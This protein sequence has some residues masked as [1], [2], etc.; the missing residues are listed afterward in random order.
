MKK[1]KV[2]VGKDVIEL[3]GNAMYLDPLTVY[4]EYIQNSVDSIDEAIKKGLLGG[5]NDGRIEINID[6]AN[7]RIVI[8]DN[9]IGITKE[10]FERRMTSIGG[11][12]KR[13]TSARGFRG[14]GRLAGLGFCQNLI[15]RSRAPGDAV[16]EQ[17]WDVRKIKSAL[18]EFQGEGDIGQLIA[19]V[20]ESRTIDGEDYPDHFF[21]VEMKSPL[22]LGQDL[23]MNFEK[24]RSYVGQVAPVPFSQTFSYAG[25]VRD[26]LEK[27]VDFREYP[28]FLNDDMGQIFKPYEDSFDYSEFKSGKLAKLELFQLSSL[29]GG[30]GAVGWVAH[31]DYQ[32][33]IP[34]SAGVGGLRARVGNMQIGERNVFVD[35]FPEERF[36]SWTI[37]EVHT[38][39]GRLIPNGRR[40]GFEH[41]NHLT[42]L[43]S[44]LLPV[45]HAIAQH[46]RRESSIRNQSKRV[47]LALMHAEAI[48]EMLDQNAITKSAAK[49]KIS[50]ARGKLAEAKAAFD[51]GIFASNGNGDLAKKLD[52]LEERFSAGNDV[53]NGSG[54][55]DHLPKA[56]RTAYL[57]IFDLIYACS[58][59]Q[60][61]ARRLID[62][63]LTRL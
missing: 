13:R 21:E 60:Q 16:C 20:T 26:Y 55:L 29:D 35:V 30:N 18:A 15:F 44:Q 37:G 54:P 1:A 61:N 39:D 63:I 17:V 56:K 57:E 46:C 31:H 51:P 27:H 43:K 42:N 3:V 47:E 6:M 36:N 33:A 24:V 41:G 62:S 58:N 25:E 2:F 40:D 49:I 14:V 28:I 10:E 9:G 12:A 38:F 53:S 45:G 7:R 48:G 50:E 59:N 11:S 52:D 34:K 4:R 32:G 5:P 23:L 22:R 19:D 8:R